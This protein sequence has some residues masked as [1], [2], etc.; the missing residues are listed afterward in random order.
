VPSDVNIVGADVL[1]EWAKLAFVTQLALGVVQIL[2][3]TTLVVVIM[4][5]GR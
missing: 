2:L 5:R 3:L 1:I 4:W